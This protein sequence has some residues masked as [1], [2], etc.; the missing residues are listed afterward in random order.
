[1]YKPVFLKYYQSEGDKLRNF[2]LGTDWWDDCDD[3]VAIRL[4]SRFHKSG[5]ICIKGIGINACMEDSV[6]SLEVFLDFEG[7]NNIPIGIDFKATDFGGN[8]SYQKRLTKLSSKYRSNEDV[9]EAVRLYR[10]ILEESEKP[11]EIVE[12][13]FL[14]VIADVIESGADDISSKTGLELIK[15]KVSKIWVM[16]G[17]WDKNPGQENNFI[18]NRR[19]RKAAN[20]FCEKCP[21]DV[22]FL[23]WEVGADVI[24]GDKLNKNDVLYDVICDHGSPYGR[25]S[26][27]PM[28]VLL[29]IIGDEAL[30]GYDAVTGIASVDE[31]N[32]ENRFNSCKEGKHK[33]VIKKMPDEYYKN[34]INELIK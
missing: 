1:M 29:A 11:I 17:R 15:E 13:G 25:M 31:I 9:E 8:P 20:I 14:Q 16:G 12:I 32:G 5:E 6:K 4:L 18:R 19:S 7:I 28:L 24:T 10:K 30:A 21:V 33:F 26:W 22:T 27:D 23:G 34:K 3:A 2:I